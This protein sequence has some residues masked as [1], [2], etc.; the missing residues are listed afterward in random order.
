M[1]EKFNYTK[2][3]LF[4]GMPDMGTACLARLVEEGVNI[5]G[6]VAPPPYAPTFRGF[7]EI[8]QYLKLNLITYQNSLK[9]E[10]FLAKIKDLN[11]DVAVVC[12]YATLFPKELLD[13]MPNRF[14]NVHPSLLP[15]YRGAN[16]Y[17]HVILND[18]EKTGITLHIMD[19]TFDTG[20]MIVSRE[21]PIEERETMGTLFNKLNYYAAE[22]LV[23]FLQKFE[24]ITE[25]KGAKQPEGDFKK[26]KDINIQNGDNII[27]WTKD[28]QYI[29]RFVRALNPFLSARTTF[30]GMPIVIHSVKAIDKKIKAPAGIILNAEKG[31]FVNSGNG[32]VEIKVLQAGTFMIG[33]GKDFVK[34]FTVSKGESFTNG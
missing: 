21:I 1:K 9:D 16:A 6:V 5:V 14:V 10:D 15:N 4:F 2:K 31:L 25:L 20:D 12:S 22:L 8:A 33:E 3:V 28:A 17:S 27:D 18:E 24:S 11:A 23:S 13:L 29:E 19:E 30:R 32:I 26:A 7:C 34:N